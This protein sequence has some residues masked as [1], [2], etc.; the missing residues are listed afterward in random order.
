MAQNDLQA[1]AVVEMDAGTARIVAHAL[2]ETLSSLS[3][4]DKA[5]CVRLLHDLHSQLNVQ[6][7]EDGLADEPQPAYRTSRM[8][9]MQATVGEQNQSDPIELPVAVGRRD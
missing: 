4:R 9:R 1:K 8:V 3:D 6:A 2:L 7:L 5:N